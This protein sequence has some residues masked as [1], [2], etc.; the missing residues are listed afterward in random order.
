MCQMDK[1]NLHTELWQQLEQDDMT[2]AERIAFLEQFVEDEDAVKKLTSLELIPMPAYLEE[3]VLETILSQEVYRPPKWLQLFSYSVKI[4]FAAAC[5]IAALFWM[6]DISIVNQ[7]QMALER[8]MEMQAREE[9]AAKRQQKI[10]NEQEKRHQAG[11]VK[12]SYIAEALQFIS[13]KIF[14]EE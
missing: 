11:A 9:A 3:E 5:A 1:K 12:S 7:E 2:D 8:M 10:L 6:P 13:E 14:V 4:T